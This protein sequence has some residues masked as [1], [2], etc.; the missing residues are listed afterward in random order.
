MCFFLRLI[1]S[2]LL[3][4]EA[5]R[6]HGSP[7][8]ILLE[9]RR[10]AVAKK[11]RIGV[12]SDTHLHQV[13]RTFEAILDRHLSDVDALF[14]VGDFTS[15]RIVDYLGARDFYG[16]CGNMDPPEIRTQLPDKRVVELGGLRFGLIHGWGSSEDLEER[17]LERFS[18]VDA[19]VY[20]HSH[21]AVSRIRGGVL[22]FNP[23]TACGPSKIGFH[24]VGILECEGDVV[25]GEIVQ[26]DGS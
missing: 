2:S 26:V 6:R 22:A 7:G 21:K 18:N 23:G 5:F 25:R 17:V 3:K 1:Y 12:L 10:G 4:T 9:E 8:T 15:P 14:H 11:L 20:G 24:S 19:V 16:V 13:T